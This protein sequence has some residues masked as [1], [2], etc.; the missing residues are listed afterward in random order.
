[1]NAAIEQLGIALP[2]LIAL[3]MALGNNP[4]ARKWAPIIGLCGQPF[5]AYFAWRTGA[6][7]VAMLVPAYTAIYLRGAWLQWVS[8]S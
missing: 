5:W 4:M 1:M 3:Y 2:G 7:G 6:A 8:R